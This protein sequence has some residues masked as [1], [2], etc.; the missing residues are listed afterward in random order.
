MRLA[1]RFDGRARQ[2]VADGA[3]D[4]L[5]VPD[6]GDFGGDVGAG[7]DVKVGGGRP[8]LLRRAVHFLVPMIS[9]Y[10]RTSSRSSRYAP[11][12]PGSLREDSL[13]VWTA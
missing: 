9:A 10:F 8:T 5:A 1:D 4:D 2:D 6:G 7:C 11:V 13:P 12:R 3:G